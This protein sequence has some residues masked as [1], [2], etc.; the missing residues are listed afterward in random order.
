MEGFQET[1][2]E[3]RYR[4]FFDH[5]FLRSCY[6]NYWKIDEKVYRSAQP[7]PLMLNYLKEQGFKTIVNLRGSRDDLVD[8]MEKRI[9]R[10]LKLILIDFKMH[11][12]AAPLKEQIIASKE[13]FEKIKYPALLHCKS[14]ADRTGIMSALYLIFKGEE[15]SYAKS[16]LSIKY[17]HIKLAKSGILDEFFE[18]YI[19]YQKK[20]G[21]INFWHWV[22]KIYNPDEVKN[23]FKVNILR[24]FLDKITN[25]E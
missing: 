1:S 25:L 18:K 21:E 5:G 11:S 23:S 3:W 6:Q 16:Q 2:E 22:S 8:Q 24:T 20:Y 4:F 10:N 7:S 19:V 13:L 9:C 15:V 14:G 17:L 12:R